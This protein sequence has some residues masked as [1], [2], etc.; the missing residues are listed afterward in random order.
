MVDGKKIRCWKPRLRALDKLAEPG[1]EPEA[2]EIAFWNVR[3]TVEVKS[4]CVPLTKCQLK[5]VQFVVTH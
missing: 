2:F 4:R 1:K 3:P 5:Y